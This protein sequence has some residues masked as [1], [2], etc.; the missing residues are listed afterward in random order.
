M[1]FESFIQEYKLTMRNMVRPRILFVVCM[2]CLG[3]FQTKDRL[4]KFSVECSRASNTCKYVKNVWNQ[5]FDWMLVHQ[6]PSNVQWSQKWFVKLTKGKSLN[7]KMIK[8]TFVE[9]VYIIW[10]RRNIIMF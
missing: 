7:C 10:T 6:K 2:A 1:E 9:V 8:V 4:N 3:R 5:V